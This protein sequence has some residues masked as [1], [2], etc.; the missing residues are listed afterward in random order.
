MK[1]VSRLAKQAKATRL[2]KK[3]QVKS[4]V[5]KAE[6]M[7]KR[8]APQ[9]VAEKAQRSL[10]ATRF[11]L[12]AKQRQ[13]AKKAQAGAKTGTLHRNLLAV[14]FGMEAKQRLQAKKAQEDAEADVKAKAAN[15][16]ADSFLRNLMAARFE[17]EAI[18]RTQVKKSE[19][20]A[21][22]RSLL[23]TRLD[24]EARQRVQL[25]EAQAEAELA[26]H[27]R[28]SEKIQR[29]LLGARLEI[30]SKQ[31]HFPANVA[32]GELLSSA[33]ASASDGSV[34]SKKKSLEAAMKVTPKDTRDKKADTPT[35]DQEEFRKMPEFPRGS[36]VLKNDFYTFLN[37]CSIQSFAFLLKSMRDPQTILWMEKFTQP[38]IKDT[39]NP[40]YSLPEN[41]AKSSKMIEDDCKLLNFH[42]LNAIDTG[43]FPSWDAYFEKLAVHPIETYTV[44]SSS[45][46]APDYDLD[47]NPSR[48]CN[49]L[50]AV[51]EQI[52]REFDNDLH[53]LSN[54]SNQTIVAYWDSVKEEEKRKGKEVA[55]YNIDDVMA[56]DGR[57]I[58][59]ESGNLMFL[60]FGVK[61]GQAPSPLRKGN[62]DLLKL[63]AT[64][65]AIHRLLN[66]P[67]RQEGAQ[68]VSNAFLRD[69]YVAR[70][71]SYF[72]G[73]VEYGVANKFMQELFS[74]L[75]VLREVEGNTA[76]IDPVRL[77]GMVLE[78]RAEV[79]LE[80]KTLSA[81]VPDEHL[82]I[83]RLLLSQDIMGSAAPGLSF[84][85]AL[86][87]GSCEV[88]NTCT[89]PLGSDPE[90]DMMD[91][92]LKD[93]EVMS[94]MA[95]N[96]TSVFE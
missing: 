87:A 34:K 94:M 12:E 75:P 29:S 55:E 28:V 37:Q 15:A 79:A 89:M 76:L 61:D 80:W 3:A 63:M 23:S 48:L 22:M 56:K 13:Q 59:I 46:Q 18:Q 32:W 93:Q 51:R 33:E 2:V 44:E 10:L 52:A 19:A 9:E 82:G 96:V 39:E 35:A 27:A 16:R 5:N 90:D 78:K 7:L 41:A 1:R 92:V 86:R 57:E 36:W 43:I 58:N 21:S 53:V 66:D 6:T 24:M 83:R 38:S 17:M 62:F 84:E 60:D 31:Q 88:D 95:I 45:G 20:D 8:A 73:N 65:E 50:L 40:S 85:E 67:S 30:E 77:A 64:Q 71:L 81:L 26:E 69:F 14:R 25:K 49:R 70:F 54:M 68:S 72:D 47:I 74:A 42:G 4:A 91:D 11:E